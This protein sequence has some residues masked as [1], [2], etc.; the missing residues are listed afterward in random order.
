[1]SSLLGTNTFNPDKDIPDLSG[2]N[3]IVTGGSAGI[4]F[5]IAAHLLQHHA[6]SVTI[7]SNKEEH[8]HS[9]LEEL[10]E[11]GDASKAHWVKCD[12][13]DLKATEKVANELAGS[14]EKLHGL[15]LNAGLGVGVYNETKDKL[16]SHFQV[17]H[18]SQFLLLLKLLP[19]LQHTPGS[20][21]VFESSE[22][23]R[24]AED[25]VQ[26]E[27]EAE[28]NKDIG[29]TK[30]YNRTKL[31]QI[32]TTRALQRRIDSGQLGFEAG[33]KVYVNAVHPGAVATDQPLQA[34]EAY[35]KLGVVGHKLVRPFMADPVATGCR[36]ALY[37]ATSQEIEEKGISG[38][39]I[40]PDKKVT[41]PSTMAQ[42]VELGERL[43][44]LSEQLLKEKLG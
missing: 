2:K 4:G 11:Y 26:F 15:I 21:V 40:V 28:I 38:Q 20:R 5:G 30:L 39:Y 24:G 7:L 19:R 8:A 35:G 16:D 6:G 9:A 34:E 44:R 31:A 17:N 13:E 3:Y 18:L 10:K 14:Q 27:N 32:L 29:P 33:Q 12:L 22:L 25:N 23:H 36:S 41:D 42:D 37:A 1:M 43:W